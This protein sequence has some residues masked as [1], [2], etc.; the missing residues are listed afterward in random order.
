M[1]EQD[2]QATTTGEMQTLLETKSGRAMA[3]FV[4]S[5]DSEHLQQVDTDFLQKLK[6]MSEQEHQ[7]TVEKSMAQTGALEVQDA[8]TNM[9]DM[10]TLLSTASGAALAKFLES[11]DTK[12]LA[13][14][15]N[16]NKQAKISTE[17][18]INL[19]KSVNT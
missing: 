15:E 11:G 12:Y 18:F 5:G 17:H 4:H 2:K 1:A 8:A 13:A 3:N 14:L 7:S 10:N 19:F 16:L 6:Q 9:R